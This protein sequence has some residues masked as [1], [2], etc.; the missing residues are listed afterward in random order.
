MNK[1]FN[2]LFLFFLI[3][4]GINQEKSELKYFKVKSQDFHKYINQKNMPTNPDLSADKAIINNE[5][6]FEIALYQDGKWFYN[7]PNL[8]IGTGT[9]KFENGIIKLYAKRTLFDMH[10][11]V[12]ALSEEARAIAIKFSDRFGPQALEMTNIN[13]NE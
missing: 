12:E 2:L 3:S 13:I 5:Y 1:F 9:W 10:I 6:P 4:C 7:L 8:D 11:D